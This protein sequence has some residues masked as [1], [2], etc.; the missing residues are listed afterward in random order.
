MTHTYLINSPLSYLIWNT[1]S[2]QN[3]YHD[4][5]LCLNTRN[6]DIVF[7]TETHT[8]N[9]TLFFPNY[10]TI[11]TDHFNGTAQGSSAIFI[12]NNI[13]YSFSSPTVNPGCVHGRRNKGGYALTF[14]FK[15][16]FVV[17]R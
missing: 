5:Q 16:L 7:I 2:Q 9:K 15:R 6:I 12:R 14:F 13:K 10:S 3:H 17:L 8:P 4:L 11:R 1:N